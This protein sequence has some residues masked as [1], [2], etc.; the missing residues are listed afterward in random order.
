M[1]RGALILAQI[2]TRMSPRQSNGRMPWSRSLRDLAL[3]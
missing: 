3:G 1:C 2:A